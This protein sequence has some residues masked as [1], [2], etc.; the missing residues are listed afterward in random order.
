MSH[1]IADQAAVF[2][3]TLWRRS[4]A[5]PGRLHHVPVAPHRVHE[6]YIPVVEYFLSPLHHT[7]HHTLL[8]HACVNATIPRSYEI[9]VIWRPVSGHVAP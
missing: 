8:P 1:Q 5:D 6:L 2:A 4:Y 7:L 3:R 9:W